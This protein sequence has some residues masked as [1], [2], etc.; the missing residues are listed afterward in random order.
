MTF[1]D[2]DDAERYGNLLEADGHMEVCPYV[3]APSVL[4]QLVYRDQSL[5]TNMGVWHVR[6]PSG[7]RATAG[8]CTAAY[9]TNPDS[10]EPCMKLRIALSKKQQSPAL[11]A[12]S[13]GLTGLRCSG[14]T[15]YDAGGCGYDRCC[16]GLLRARG[17]QPS[18]D[19]SQWAAPG[20]R[21]LSS[22]RLASCRCLWPGQIL[23]SCSGPHRGCTALSFSSAAAATCRCLSSCQ[24][25]CAAR[26]HGR[27]AQKPDDAM[28]KKGLK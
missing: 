7:R 17:A 2:G 12:A 21:C 6:M 14:N 13:R 4:L 19:L 3:D 1:E 26:V 20:F 15:L 25:H 24:Q 16:Q 18:D 8:F 22:C 5:E 23:T 11:P 27:M 28:S 10:R 9:N